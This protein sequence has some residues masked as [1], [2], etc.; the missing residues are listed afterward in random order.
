MAIQSLGE[1]VDHWRHFQLLMEDSPLL[2]QP[3]VAES[4]EKMGKDPF[5]LDVLSHAID[6]WAFSQIG[7][8]ATFLAS[9]F[10]RRAETRATFF[11]VAF[12]PF[13]I[14]GG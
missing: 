7:G 14:L 3:D 4:F 11:P 8:F 5:E 13:G 9:C 10:F 6:C 2:L 1:L 12:F